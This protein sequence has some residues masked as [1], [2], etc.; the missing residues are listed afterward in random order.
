LVSLGSHHQ[1]AVT[2]FLRGRFGEALAAAQAGRALLERLG[3]LPF[4]RTSFDWVTA[5]TWFARGDLDAAGGLL[6][7]R[8]RGAPATDLDRS[9]NVLQ[10]PLWARVLRSQGRAIEVARLAEAGVR[11]EQRL[12][13]PLYIELAQISVRAQA[14]WAAGDHGTAASVLRSALEIEDRVRLVP[15]VGSP[16]LDLAMVLA[17]SGSSD[18]ALRELAHVLG[19]VEKLGTVSLVAQAGSE[20]V[21]LLQLAVQR[22]VRASAAAAALATLGERTPP[23]PVAVPGCREVLSSREVEVLRLIVSGA[24]NREITEALVVSLNTVKTHVSHVI[25]KLGVRSRAEA[26]AR[27]RAEHLV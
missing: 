4:L 5:C 26:A 21:P 25:T 10:V 9:L 2:S 18:E 17:Q 6:A 19:T 24:S 1:R 8:R 11:D 20:V 7:E 12:T 13:S 22:G 27:A 15:F 16:R 23:Q 3:G 14:A